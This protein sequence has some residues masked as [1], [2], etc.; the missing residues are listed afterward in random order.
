MWSLATA[1]QNVVQAPAARMT[2]AQGG[3]AWKFLSGGGPAGTDVIP[4][5]LS[6]GEMVI[7][8]ASARRFASQLT[9][10]NAGVQA[11]LPQRGRQRHQHR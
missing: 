3:V 6:P 2:A 7:N 10:I 5:M 9:A 4:A 11:G 1:S 8:A